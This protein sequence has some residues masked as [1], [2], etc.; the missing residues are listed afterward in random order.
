MNFDFSDDQ[1]LLQDQVRRYLADHCS[2]A[3]VR[4]VLEGRASHAE[5]VWK[6]LTE[7]GLIGTSIPESYGGVGAGYLE[8][9]L[10]AEEV[11]AALAPVPFGS[12]VYL[13]AEALMRHGSEEQKS[14]LLPDIAPLRSGRR[15]REWRAKRGAPGAFRRLRP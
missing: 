4:S 7:M 10:V 12:T 9:C 13:V 8:L 2:S 6:G 11:G 3:V 5:E 1:K 14:R 15:S